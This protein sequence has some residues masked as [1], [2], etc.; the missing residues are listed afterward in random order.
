MEGRIMSMSEPEVEQQNELTDSEK[1]I[2]R[3]DYL[4]HFKSNLTMFAIDT[5]GSPTKTAVRIRSH[6]SAGVL[7]RIAKSNT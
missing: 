3:F 2:I 1:E 4:A 6:R 5:H 7:N